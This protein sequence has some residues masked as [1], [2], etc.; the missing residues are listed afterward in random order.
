MDDANVFI[1]GMDA[2]FQGAGQLD[3]LSDPD[4]AQTG[5]APEFAAVV[6]T[7]RAGQST[8]T[9]TDQAG[10]SHAPDPTV[11][12]RWVLGT[13]V[14]I[15]RACERWVGGRW[16]EL[17]EVASPPTPLERHI[18]MHAYKLRHLL[19]QSGGK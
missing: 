9:G 11:K 17:P 16:M 15:S 2:C 10:T 8:D 1:M 13:L 19:S 7:T 12:V 4:L 6:V 5:T 18:Q 3:E 14:S